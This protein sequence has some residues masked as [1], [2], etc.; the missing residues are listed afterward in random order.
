METGQVI[1]CA[2]SVLS[3]AFHPPFFLQGLGEQ[4]RGRWLSGCPRSAKIRQSH[5]AQRPS[6]H[7]TQL[8][9]LETCRSRSC[10]T[11]TFA[12]RRSGHLGPGSDLG[13]LVLPPHRSPKSPPAPAL[14][15]LIQFQLTSQGGW[16]QQETTASSGSRW[17][18]PTRQ[19]PQPLLTQKGGKPE[20]GFSNKRARRSK[21]ASP[22][23]PP[24]ASSTP[25][26]GHQ[27]EDA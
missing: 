7:L 16:L 9:G 24:H 14:G 17:T 5:G 4:S 23:K 8:V 19:K 25:Q 18:G 20:G 13:I 10:S 2:F 11:Q 1:A 21:D 26:S 15:S 6:H 3:S 22:G 12:Q 27:K